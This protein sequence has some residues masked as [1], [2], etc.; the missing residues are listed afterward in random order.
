MSDF[1]PGLKDTLS[2]IDFDPEALRAKYRQERDKRLRTDGNEQY[3]EVKGDFTRYI[4]DPYVDP[5][6]SRA[7]L[8]ETVEVLII[9][10]GFGGLLA[11]ARLRE[12]GFQDIR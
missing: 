3:V 11:G 2:G 12:A 1:S 6:F 4:D 7:P 9:G 10:G 5:G 8:D